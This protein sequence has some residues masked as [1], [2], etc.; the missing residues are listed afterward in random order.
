MIARTLRRRV[1]LQTA[2]AV[3]ARAVGYL[4]CAPDIPGRPVEELAI[5]IESDSDCHLI[6]EPGQPARRR[7]ALEDVVQYLHQ[8]LFELSIEDGPQAP[9]VHAASLRA[10]GRRLL[11]VGAKGVGK[12]TLTLHLVRAGYEVEGDENVFV[13]RD[14]VVARPRGL[15]VKEDALALLPD[16]APTIAAAP[17]AFDDLGERVFNLDPRAIG[18]PWRIEQG[19]ADV[20][21]LLRSNHGGASSIRPIPPLELIQD[22]MGETGLPPTAR[23]AAVASIAAAFAAAKG[24]DLSLGD[25]VGALRCIDRVMSGAFGAF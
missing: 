12:T 7:H 24:F 25:H 1:I 22:A 4:D 15:R 18:A 17:A 19:R 10:R 8:R 2:D 23:G 21:V 3:V 13:G 5:A 14:A 16:I 11:L 6:R 9:I 20:V